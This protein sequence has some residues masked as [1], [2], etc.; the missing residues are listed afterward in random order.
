MSLICYPNQE[1]THLYIPNVIYK[2]N[3]IVALFVVMFILCSSV[4]LDWMNEAHYLNK[5]FELLN[6]QELDS[7][8]RHFY[9]SVRTK[10][11]KEYSK[12]AL[13]GMRAAINRHLNS[14]PF[15]RNI[16]LMNDR[17][18]MASNQVLTGLIKSLKREGKDISQHKEPICEE[19]LVKLYNSG[20]FSDQSA[21]TLLNKVMYDIISQF[22]RRGQ[23]GLRN[24]R[25]DSFKTCVDAKG[26]Q[27]ICM[28]YNE[29]D[30]NHHGLD[31]R[32]NIK[33]ARMYVNEGPFCPVKSFQKYVSKLHPGLSDF[34]QRPLKNVQE[35]KDIWY[36]NKAVG[37]NMLSSFMARMS[38]EAGL[39][40][41]YTNHCIRAHVTSTLHSQGFSSRAIMSVTGHRNVA[42]LA[43][44]IKPSEDERESLSRALCPFTVTN[45][46]SH[47]TPSQC[48][49]GVASATNKHEA[50]ITPPIVTSP[51][52]CPT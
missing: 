4:L 33:Q 18:F 6:V 14:P 43:S 11:G 26:R 16:N 39:S 41:R 8:L 19:D 7:L 27:Y 10:D 45:E 13:V 34:F 50:V 12:A 22:G 15:T 17:D 51:S 49:S 29:A 47:K 25:K 40:N 1:V 44:Y 42:S 28:A 52:R 9:A 20:V 21:K 5:E 38:N 23:E 32:E 30:K 31:S 35:N 48:L 3:N 36:Y 24:L 37:V 2:I 46:N